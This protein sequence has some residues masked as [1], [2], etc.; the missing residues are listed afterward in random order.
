MKKLLLFLLLL[1][2][3]IGICQQFDLNGRKPTKLPAD[4]KKELYAYIEKNDGIALSTD[5]F[6]YVPVYNLLSRTEKQLTDGIYFYTWGAH[7]SGS[8]FIYNKGK[9]AILRDGNVAEILTDYK[10]FLTSNK[11]SEPTQIEY[12]SIIASFFKHKYADQKMLEKVGVVLPT[13]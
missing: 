5:Q 2:P 11:I 8:L 9:M 12:L 4:I 10:S 1:I 3:S 6:A 7:D 13:K